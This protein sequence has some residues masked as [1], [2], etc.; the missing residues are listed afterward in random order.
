MTD[1]YYIV[2]G[3]ITDTKGNETILC[4]RLSK[5][6]KA[7]QGQI[8]VQSGLTGNSTGLHYHLSVLTSWL[9]QT[10]VQPFDYL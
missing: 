5:G 8:I 2:N 3:T 1:M 4:C 10:Y 9:P 6:D 7:V